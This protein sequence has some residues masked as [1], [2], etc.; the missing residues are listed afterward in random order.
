[1][2]VVAY[3]RR[4]LSVHPVFDICDVYAN[5]DLYGPEKGIYPKDKGPMLFAYPHCFCY[6]KPVRDL[7]GKKEINRMEQGG[8]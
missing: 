2:D 3:R 4:M 7:T 6:L 1:M 5:V 8:R